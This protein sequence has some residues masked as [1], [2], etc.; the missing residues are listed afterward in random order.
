MISHDNSII[1]NLDVEGEG[2]IEEEQHEEEDDNSHH[3]SAIKSM[4]DSG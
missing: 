3:K 4:H 1:D 2:K